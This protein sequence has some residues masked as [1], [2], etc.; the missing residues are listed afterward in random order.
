MGFEVQ[1]QYHPE[2]SKGEY[3]KQEM[4]TGNIKV[5]SPYE[6]VSLDVVA[7]KVMALM[8][9]RNILVVGVEIFE[10]VKKPI[11]FKESDDG[12]VIKN[13]KFRYDDGPAIAGEDLAEKAEDQVEK[14]KQL[15]A[16]N[17]ELATLLQPQSTVAAPSAPA[18]PGTAIQKAVPNTQG[19]GPILRYE[20]FD[21]EDDIWVQQAKKQIK[22]FAFT[23]GKRY[24]IYGENLKPVG[25]LGG[26]AA[27]GLYYTVQDDKGRKQVVPNQLFSPVAA[28]KLEHEGELRGQGGGLSDNGLRWDGVMGD[29]DVPKLR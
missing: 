7:G 12:I 5:G 19:L 13:K 23:R 4:Q 27:Q 6:E 1:Y 8:A 9:R 22:D 14:L 24:A 29:N 11:A 15:L 16:S 21:P 2:I 26:V 25:S 28:P 3:N 18:T 10:I 20:F 17:P